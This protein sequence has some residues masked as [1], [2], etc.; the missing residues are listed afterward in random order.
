MSRN[1]I[2]KKYDL[3]LLDIKMPILNGE[4]VFQYIMNY[5]NNIQGE[6][7]L[8]NVK[9]PYIIAVTAYSLKEYQDKYLKLGFEAFIPKPI[10]I[11]I[12]EK[13]MN[14]FINHILKN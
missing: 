13:S 2:K 1:I 14:I 12:L 7:K 8:L 5:Y 10:N 9:K 3:I 4:L 6:Y 11:K